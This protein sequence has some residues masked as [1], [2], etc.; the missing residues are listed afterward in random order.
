MDRSARR[1]CARC[2]TPRSPRRSP[3]AACR[4]ICRAPPQ[5][6]HDRHRRRQGVGGDGAAVEDHWPGDARPGSSS[7]ATATRC[8][9]SASRSSRPRIRCPTRR[10]ARRRSA[11]STWSQGLTRRRSRALPDLR[12]RL[13]AARAAGAGAR[14]STTSRR[15]IARC[16]KSRRDDRRDELRAPASVGDQGRPARAPRAIRRRSSRC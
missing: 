2:S 10:A 15:S 14:R 1:S 7:P 12:R 11:S 16:S 6:P 9:A 3:R 4:R 13:G 5:G 8:R